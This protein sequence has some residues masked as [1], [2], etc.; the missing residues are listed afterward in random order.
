MMAYLQLSERERSW[1]TYSCFDE[2]HALAQ[3]TLEMAPGL[4]QRPKSVVA[5]LEGEEES[6]FVA[7]PHLHVWLTPSE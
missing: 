6:V 3:V 7:L 5:R 4:R 1:W 2:M